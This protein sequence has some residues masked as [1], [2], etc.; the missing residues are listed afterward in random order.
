MLAKPKVLVEAA[1]GVGQV[2]TLALALE[3]HGLALVG[4]GGEVVVL[5][6]NTKFVL[7]LNQGLLLDLDTR[8]DVASDRVGQTQAFH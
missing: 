3:E 7:L 1:D 8:F 5:T 4:V 2:T 6:G